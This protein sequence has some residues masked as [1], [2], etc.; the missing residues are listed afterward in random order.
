MQ[1]NNL[2]L[3]ALVAA[4][5]AMTQTYTLAMDSDLSEILIHDE[6]LIDNTWRSLAGQVKAGKS[7]ACS[8]HLNCDGTIS[9]FVMRHPSG[10][11]AFDS[12]VR[13]AIEVPGFARFEGR[14][15]L[16]VNGSFSGGPNPGCSLSSPDVPMGTSAVERAIAQKRLYH[17]N[18]IKIVKNNISKGEKVLGPN[19]GKLSLSINFLGNEYKEIGD[20]ANADANFKRALAIRQKANGPDSKEVVQTMGDMAD[21]ALA[22]GDRD[23]AEKLFQQTLTMNAKPGPELAKVMEHYAAMLFKE[24]KTDAA[25]KIYDQI[26]AVKSG[27]PLLIEKLDLTVESKTASTGPGDTKTDTKAELKTDKTETKET[28]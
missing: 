23:G 1:K 10:D 27:K 11:A 7:A 17:L 26:G 16:F 8:F 5:L 20:W 22:R 24:K 13:M 3:P 4:I 9:N 25:Q 12:T 15:F 14:P 28:K 18:A 19:S 21:L 6:K 2:T